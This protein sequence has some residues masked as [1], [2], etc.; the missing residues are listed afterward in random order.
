MYLCACQQQRNRVKVARAASEKPAS[1]QS[2]IGVV[3][4]CLL[5][6]LSQTIVMPQP[7]VQNMTRSVFE[8]TAVKSASLSRFS[9]GF[10]FSSLFSSTRIP[11]EECLGNNGLRIRTRFQGMLSH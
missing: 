8:A 4:G 7:L 11:R 6:L 1:S 5:P 10:S 3:Q 2:S 9:S